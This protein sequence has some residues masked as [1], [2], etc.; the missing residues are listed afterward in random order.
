MRG[1]SY[2]QVRTARQI[3][4]PEFWMFIPAWKEQNGSARYM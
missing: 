1:I 4:L 2:V 3:L